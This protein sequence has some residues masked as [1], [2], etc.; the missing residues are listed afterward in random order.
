M[1][2]RT[3]VNPYGSPSTPYWIVAEAPG[4]NEH[5][6]Q[7]SCD[8]GYKCPK[9]CTGHVLIGATGVT[10]D[11]WLERAGL[12]RKSW[13]LRNVVRHWPNFMGDRGNGASAEKPRPEEIEA[14][15]PYLLEDLQTYKPEVVVAFGSV[16]MDALLAGTEAYA[17]YH[18]KSFLMPALNGRPV[19]LHESRGGGICIPTVHAAAGFRKSHAAAQTWL[20]LKAAVQ[21]INSDRDNW[22]PL[23]HIK[24]T[25][26]ILTTRAQV[27][28][29]L[30]ETTDLWVG[31]PT[32]TE[33]W[34][35]APES[36]Q[37]ATA[38]GKAYF[39]SIDSGEALAAFFEFA[40]RPII[41]HNLLSDWDMFDAFV[42]A[43]NLNITFTIDD[44]ADTMVK[45]FVT[46]REA[47]E[48]D[49][50]SDESSV[51]G[52]G[53]KPLSYKY[54]GHRMKT[55]S[56]VTAPALN[57]ITRRY[58]TKVWLQTLGPE[59]PE[60]VN[61]RTHRPTLDDVYIGRPSKW[62]NP[63]P[64]I[65]S[66]KANKKKG[67]KGVK[68][69]TRRQVIRDY[70]KWI[71]TQPQLLSS[72][73]QLAGKKLVCWCAPDEC[74]GD[75]L[76]DLVASL[77]GPCDPP[78]E[79]RGHKLGR[80]LPSL[81]IVPDIY[82]KWA[83]TLKDKPEWKDYI[84]ARFGSIPSLRTT[85]I[86]PHVFNQYA[87]ED[88]DY[89]GRLDHIQSAEMDRVQ[90]WEPYKIDMAV[91]PMLRR[92]TATGIKVDLDKLR[93]LEV[94]VESKAAK[95]YRSLRMIAFKAG[96]RE[97]NP[98]SNDQVA[99]LYFEA[100]KISPNGV[101]KT[102]KGRP[103]VDE[104]GL[105]SLRLKS[106]TPPD[107]F[108]TLLLEYKG[109]QKL[110]S[111][112]IRPLPGRLGADGRVH[113]NWRH[114]VAV[115]GR[116]ACSRPNLL[117]F[118]VRDELGKRLRACF[119]AGEGN[120]FLSVDL[121]QI[122]LRILASLSGD[123][124]M[125]QAFIEGRD[126]HDEAAIAA[127]GIKKVPKGHPDF[128]LWDLKRTQAKEL[129]FGSAY[130]LTA[131]GY[132][133]RLAMKGIDLPLE[134]CEIALN[135]KK[136]EWAVAF[137]YLAQAGEDCYNHPD[138]IVRDMWGRIRY[139]PMVWSPVEWA[140]EEARR[141]AGNMLIQGGAQG[142]MKMGMIKWDR[143]IRH[144][145]PDWSPL[146]QIH[147]DLF[148]EGP[149]DQ[150]DKAARLT[151]ECF[152]SAVQDRFCVPILADAKKGKSWGEKKNVAA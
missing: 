90:T 84:E 77:P 137:E 50:D 150:V 15:L 143:E 98:D 46:A 118:P 1:A 58:L 54:S 34:P 120:I 39:I 30:R 8:R 147:D 144:Q 42:R 68:G 17:L 116:L 69:R 145:L 93:A 87:C 100:F 43:H 65:D 75:V 73:H 25:Y 85:D 4:K 64:V 51:V 101:K 132:Q 23:Q 48:G 81:L 49:D 10:L 123:P 55:W 105:A 9:D 114:T 104:K 112:F 107:I 28:E 3:I 141:Q 62:G 12:P 113:P 139:L 148:L 83:S 111:A 24:T 26:K 13:H 122:E 80:R 115:S 130:G 146:L 33:G 138:A 36:L 129:N 71:L 31:T 19:R 22:F 14:D 135:G 110:L 74:H 67:I 96:M 6:D 47:A 89:T 152:Q 106:G 27:R 16:A 11:T 94:D 76:A 37:F 131:D 32:D 86:D 61:K 35:D 38:P 66:I 109:L 41:V 59:R 40:P 99:R 7:K 95:L 60:V 78:V 70:K 79:G 97:F 128:E 72:L 88:P 142:V 121:S 127:F 29:A 126:L 18:N 52:Q 44:F 2:K 45:T 124:V 91:I 103:S 5:K 117:A 57:K 82:K 56:E 102:A 140:A 63:F 119:V 21:Y 134:D 151:V 108:R 20:G 149:E 92:M 136:Q 53:L 133:K 125:I